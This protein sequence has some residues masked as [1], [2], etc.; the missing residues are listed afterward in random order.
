[1]LGDY[2]PSDHAEK[3]SGSV[4]ATSNALHCQITYRI[5]LT[6][7]WSCTNKVWISLKHAASIKIIGLGS[8]MVPSCPI[9]CL[10]WLKNLPSC[11]VIKDHSALISCTIWDECWI[12]LLVHDE[13]IILKII[14][15]ALFWA[16]L[17]KMIVDGFWA[18]FWT[19]FGLISTWILEHLWTS[20]WSPIWVLFASNLNLFN[21]QIKLFALVIFPVKNKQKYQFLKNKDKLSTNWYFYWYICRTYQVMLNQRKLFPNKK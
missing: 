18:R 17:L 19:Y 16:W 4:L 9:A 6:A 2:G 20:I 5:P 14:W 10:K 1:M 7:I 12:E 21:L 8:R 15:D 13:Q 11:T 3:E